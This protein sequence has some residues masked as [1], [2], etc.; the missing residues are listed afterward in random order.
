V[1]ELENVSKTYGGSAVAAVSCVDLRIER[2]T[3]LVLLGE[4]GS[5]KTTT[6]KMINRLV[7]PSSGTIRLDGRDVE[8]FDPIDLRRRIGYAF[9]GIGL[10]PHMTVAENVAT[11]P[12]LLGWSRTDTDARVAELLELVGLPAT[13]FRDRYP[14]EL[15]GGQRQRVGVARALAARS[16]VL[17]MDEP[18]GALDPITRDELQA[19]LKSLQRALGLTVVLVTHDVTEAVLLADRIAVMK[20]GRV[21]GH[22]TPARLMAEPPHE[23]VAALMEMPRR[24]ARRVAALAGAAESGPGA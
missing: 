22:D 5:G 17:L 18:F 4:S 11:V 20:D 8:S 3:L 13:R 12:R 7:E 1:I 2:E 24:Q 9:Q 10:F 19:E 15:S 23:Y 14:R 16:K 21:L 6:L